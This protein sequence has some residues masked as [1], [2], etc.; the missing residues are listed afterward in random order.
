[1]PYHLVLRSM[2]VVALFECVARSQSSPTLSS[3][4]AESHSITEPPLDKYAAVDARCRAL[5]FYDTNRDAL[6]LCRGT[7]PA[8][9]QAESEGFRKAANEYLWL[10]SRPAV[11]SCTPVPPPS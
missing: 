5:A 4:G 2:I 3:F 6:K 11:G 7:D 1:M 9:W 8:I 10:L